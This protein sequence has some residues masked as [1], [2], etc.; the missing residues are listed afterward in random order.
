MGA[1]TDELIER[2]RECVRQRGWAQRE[3]AAELE[4]KTPAPERVD[5]RQEE[6]GLEHGLALAELRRAKGGRVTRRKAKQRP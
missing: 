3:L 2:L 6:T 1:K 4:H 5:F